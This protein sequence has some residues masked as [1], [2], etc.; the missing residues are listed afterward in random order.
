V[1][2]SSR[3]LAARRGSPPGALLAVALGLAAAGCNAEV[4]G[5][6]V[7]RE[8]PRNVPAFLGVAVRDGV[9]VKVTAGAP[10]RVVVSGDENVV[11]HVE[12]A[13]RTDVALGIQVLELSVSFAYTATHPLVVT[14]D[15]PELR[16][17]RATDAA[18]VDAR[19][20]E[21]ERFR[22]EASDGS[23][24]TLAGLGQGGASTLEAVLSGVQHGAHLDARSYPVAAATV[25]LSGSASLAAVRASAVV[26][27]V[28]RAGTRVENAGAGTCDV[29]DE[30]GALVSC[31]LG[32]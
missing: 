5:N 19:S 10:Q 4:Q 17:V 14:I 20:V 27:G 2:R 21:T 22:V 15:V 7:L 26:T 8:E 1:E 28:A 3:T 12:A 30:T 18:Q 11:Q 16:L 31:A 24:V 25:D 6:G 23:D 13:V 29:R 32:P 9:Q